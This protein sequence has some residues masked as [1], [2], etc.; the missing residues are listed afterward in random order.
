[1]TERVWQ[2]GMCSCGFFMCEQSPCFG[3]V[4]TSIYFLD[5]QFLEMKQA[6]RMTEVM[7]LART[8]CNKDC[9]LD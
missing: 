8:S 5:R 7:K 9:Y 3:R 4:R 2:N 6:T 1:M